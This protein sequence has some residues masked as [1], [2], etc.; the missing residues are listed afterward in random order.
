VPRRVSDSLS[1]SDVKIEFF[2]AGGK[3]GQHRNKTETAV[4]VVHL[5]TGLT[6][7]IA[8]ERSQSTNQERAL[9]VLSAR[10]LAKRTTDERR[11]RDAV[12]SKMHGSGDIAERFRSYLWREGTVVDH[13][14]G[15]TAPLAK[16]LDGDFSA[17]A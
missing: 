1:L 7:T 9:A 13:Q 17:F 4:R 3:G 15:K 11:V 6:A 5:P 8:D 14:T 2:R 10:V 12:R 16:V